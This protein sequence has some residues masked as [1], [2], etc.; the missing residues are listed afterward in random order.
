MTNPAHQPADRDR[1]LVHDTRAEIER[2][3]K[4]ILEAVERHGYPEA[5]R[6]ALRLAIEEAIVNAFRHGHKT[7]DEDKPVEVEWRIDDSACTITV[8]DQGPGF[9]PEAIPDPT[10][11]ENLDVPSGRGIMLMRAYMSSVEFN[12]KGNAV[13][14]VYERSK[15]KASR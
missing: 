8:R 2:V 4:A 5:S 3:E 6:F 10:L 13:T 11:D 12:D 1:S 14:M 15:A 7:L 9:Q